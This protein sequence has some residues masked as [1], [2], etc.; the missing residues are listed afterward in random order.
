MSKV[1]PANNIALVIVDWQERLFAAM[2]EDIRG[3]YLKNVANLKWFCTQL[4]IPIICSEQYPKG[5]GATVSLLQPVEAV[6][7][8]SFSALNEPQFVASLEKLGR[9]HILLAGMETH[10]C[11]AQTAHDLVA[12]DYPV[13]VVADG[14]LSRKK[15]DWKI[16]L[17]RMVVD[18]AR[19]TTSE[20][21]M[22][23]IL[24]DANHGLFKA[25]SKRIK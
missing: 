13:W 7:K 4:G 8:I 14:C 3:Q 20:A 6:E 19:I 18:G 24:G 15:L 11:V 10:I 5:L 25:L 17:Q 22:F 12:K 2:P 16:A 23:E 9:R 1:N 21:I